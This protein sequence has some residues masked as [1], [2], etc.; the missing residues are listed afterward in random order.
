MGVLNTGRNI[1]DRFTRQYLTTALWCTNDDSDESG[2]EPLER[3]YTV[4]DC[5]PDLIAWAQKD[6]DRFRE[7]AGARLDEHDD[8]T[9]AAHDFWLTRNGHGAGFWDGDWPTHGDA[10]D[11]LC[12]TFGECEIYVGDD[13]I[14][15]A[16]DG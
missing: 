16:Y 12:K 15:Y 8:E 5:S 6:C 10:L 3:N 13:G 2:G 11:T 1:M 4:E 9:D 14:L 7:L